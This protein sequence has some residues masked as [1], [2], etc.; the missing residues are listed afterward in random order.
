MHWKIVLQVQ[1]LQAYFGGDAYP[2]KQ[3]ERITCT[4]FWNNVWN[5]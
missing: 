3:V 5:F 4:M 1:G 2:P